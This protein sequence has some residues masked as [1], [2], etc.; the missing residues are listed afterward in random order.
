[1]VAEH[2][3]RS[4]GSRDRG[5]ESHSGHECLVVVY[6]CAF[7]CVYVQVEALQRA[8]HPSE[9]SYRLS[10][11]KKLRKLSPVLQKRERAP[12]CGINEKK[13]YVGAL[14]SSVTLDFK[15]IVKTGDGVA[16]FFIRSFHS[17]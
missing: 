1:M 17:S 8:D 11:I 6:V 2:C 15:Q 16:Y 4:L 3:L 9:E 13:I 12:K 14:N 10:L 7:F 5:F